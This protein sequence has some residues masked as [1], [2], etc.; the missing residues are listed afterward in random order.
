M[1][2]VIIPHLN[3]PDALEACL[4]SLEAQ[5][6]A[7]DQFEII[8]VDNGSHALPVEVWRVI[9]ARACSGDAGP[10]PGRRATQAWLRR[11]ARSWRSSTP[12]AARI[13]TGCTAS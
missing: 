11:R 10:D 12:I 8:V 9:R 7:R 1:I 13:R 5:T 2:S 6:L 4:S 3:Q